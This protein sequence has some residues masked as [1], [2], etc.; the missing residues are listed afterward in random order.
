MLKTNQQKWKIPKV[1]FEEIKQFHSAPIYCCDSN[2]ANL[3]NIIAWEK[4][5]LIIASLSRFPLR[6]TR[7][8]P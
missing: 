4:R 2:Q 3:W 5:K 7:V 1:G 6:G 8:F